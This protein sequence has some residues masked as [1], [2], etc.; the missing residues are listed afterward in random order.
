MLEK[1]YMAERSLAQSEA[2]GHL[3]DAYNKATPKK[4]QYRIGTID[5]E[6][7]I[8]KWQTYIGPLSHLTRDH[9]TTWS[10]VQL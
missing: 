2:G 4:F 10:D 3:R 7:A 1:R 6:P 5:P 9:S 8:H